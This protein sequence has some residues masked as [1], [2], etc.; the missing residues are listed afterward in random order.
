MS[1]RTAVRGAA[2]SVRSRAA[3]TRLS[4]GHGLTEPLP[5]APVLTAPLDYAED[6]LTPAKPP[7]AWTT[8]EVIFIA[9]LA[10]ACV[11]ALWIGLS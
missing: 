5:D 1:A 8:C 11:I 4:E 7:R 9:A 6:E 2:R 10:A 3:G